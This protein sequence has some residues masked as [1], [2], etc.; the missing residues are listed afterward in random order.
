MTTRKA[1]DVSSKLCS[2]G[3]HM[4]KKADHCQYFLYVNGLRTRIRTKISHGENEIDDHLIQ[5]MAAQ[6]KLDKA[7]FLRLVDCT[8]SEEEYRG[9]MISKGFVEAPSET[10]PSDRSKTKRFRSPHSKPRPCSPFR[11]RP[12][13][14]DPSPALR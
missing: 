14:A 4:N 3:F 12:S 6:L 11:A 5:K 13:P 7:D 10:D 1:R 9:L 8:M 2:N